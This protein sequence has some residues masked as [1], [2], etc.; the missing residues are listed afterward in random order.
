MR[1]LV[2]DPSQPDP[3]AIAAAAASLREGGLVAFPTET[4]YGLGV[5]PFNERAVERLFA[6]KG[7]PAEKGLILHLGEREQITAIVRSFPPEA[8]A[9]ARRFFP[10]PLT[11]VLPARPSISAAVTGGRDT[12]AV[13]MPDHPVAL[14]LARAFGGPIAA[15]SANPSGAPPPTTAEQVADYLAG[16][17]DVLLDA[18]PSPGGVPSTILDLT[19]TSPRILRHGAVA[20]EE[21]WR[22]LEDP[23]PC[24]LPETERGNAPDS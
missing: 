20:E 9:L 11:L 15:P 6:A 24:P 5:D 23:S 8:A 22:A 14:A 3:A 4:V 16:A 7:R 21:I 13:R 1:R 19:T 10:G 2:V 12:V 17:I 18:G